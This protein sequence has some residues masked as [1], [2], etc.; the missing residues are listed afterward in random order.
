MCFV[1]SIELAFL[2]QNDPFSSLKILICRKYSYQKLTKF[3]QGN[4]VLNAAASDIDGV[5]W[6]DT[7][8]S[9]THLNRPI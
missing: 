5:L 6:R 3:S 2:L 9:S 7:F 1:H 8:V 4:N